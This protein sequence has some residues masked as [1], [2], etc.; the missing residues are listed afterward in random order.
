MPYLPKIEFANFHLR[1]G[2]D[3]RLLDL[4]SEVVLPALTTPDFTREYR[5]TEY[6]FQ[7]LRLIR[8]ESDPIDTPALVGRIRKRHVMDVHK[9]DITV[10]PEQVESTESSLFLLLLDSHRIIYLHETQHAPGLRALRSTIQ[11]AIAQYRNVLVAAIREEVR[12]EGISQTLLQLGLDYDEVPQSL[13]AI[14]QIF[15]SPELEIVPLSSDD[16]LEDFLKKFKV[17]QA[18]RFQFVKTNDEIDNTKLFEEV[19]HQ[20]EDIGSDATELVH[21]SEKGL[22]KEKVREKFSEVL[23]RG[24]V[25]ARFRGKDEHNHPV[26][27]TPD[28]YAIR[29]PAKELAEKRGLLERAKHVFDTFIEQIKQGSIHLPDVNEDRRTKLRNM[30]RDLKVEEEL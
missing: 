18:V 5:D 12:A 15:P 27:G 3:L 19:R 4:F 23:N 6:W 20:G 14:S 26:A 28:Q 8:A 22:Q 9:E 24:T 10:E 29:V 17:L 16:S 2:D 1:F 30:T 13:R 7:E 25:A 11:R 21:T